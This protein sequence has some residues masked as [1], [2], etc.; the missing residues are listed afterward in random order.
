MGK[1][2]QSIA[3]TDSRTAS[4][5]R[6]KHARELEI[7]HDALEHTIVGVNDFASLKQKADSPLQ[8]A[9]VFLTIRTF[10]S[11]RT[12]LQV[13]EHGYYQQAMTLVRMALEDQ[14]VAEDIEHHPP[15]LAALLDDKGRLGKGDLT[16][17]KMAERLSPKAKV[18]W[19]ARYGMLSEHGAHPRLKSMQGLVATDLP[20]DQRGPR[21][22]GHYDAM[23]VNVVVYYAAQTL[24]E[25]M[26]TLTKLTDEVGIDWADRA[27]PTFQEVDSLWKRL[28]GWADGQLEELDRN[29]T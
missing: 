15:T 10:K 21:L 2:L 8:A 23:W 26:A 5:I 1:F 7:L 16:L 12:A 3:R 28:D 27:M 25:A 4:T 22:G 29:D 18:A 11:L 6:Q 9:R 20:R 13:L 24:V 19:D 17:G 14:L